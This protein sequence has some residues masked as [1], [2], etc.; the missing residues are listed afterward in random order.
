MLAFNNVLALLI[1][2]VLNLF[3]YILLLRFILQKLRANWFNP[4][5]QTVVR[6]TEPL[7]KTFRKFIP[8]YRGF[9]LSILLAAFLLE[10]IELWIL[11]KLRIPINPKILGMFIIAIAELAIKFSNIYLYATIIY[12]LISWFPNL[13]QSPVAEITNLLVNPILLRLR[14][15]VPPV[16]GFDLTPLILIIILLLLNMLIFSPLVFRGTGLLF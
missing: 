11:L 2:I 16:N 3:V 4:I 13:N 5:S 1:N 8:G 14:R 6:F 9:D 10:L 15:I 12:A 7:L